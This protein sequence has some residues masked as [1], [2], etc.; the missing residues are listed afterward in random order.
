MDAVILIEDFLKAEKHEQERLADLVEA[1]REEIREEVDRVFVSILLASKGRQFV[2]TALSMAETERKRAGRELKKIGEI[3]EEIRGAQAERRDAQD[4][5]DNFAETGPQAGTSRARL[6]EQI[7]R[8][9]SRIEV[10]KN[11]R[12]VPKTR[13][14]KHEYQAEALTNLAGMLE[15]TFTVDEAGDT[16][17]VLRAALR[18]EK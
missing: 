1:I 10:L 11:R 15:K 13:S 8:A 3:G 14:E 5:L 16:L 2:E 12:Y 9:N 18:E 17:D 7:K 4:R 6:R